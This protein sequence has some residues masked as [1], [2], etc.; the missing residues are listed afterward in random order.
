M[1]L[2]STPDENRSQVLKFV[3]P[4][5]LSV[6]DELLA[7]SSEWAGMKLMVFDG[8]VPGAYES[9]MNSTSNSKPAIES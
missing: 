6:I 8:L 3:A 4:A 7:Q 9:T 5:G 1:S 2:A